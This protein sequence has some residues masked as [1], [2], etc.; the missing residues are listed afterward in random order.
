MIV[1]YALG[2]G[3]GHLTRVRA[4]AHTLGHA[5]D[6]V[7]IATVSRW[8][9]DRRVTGGAHVV[10]LA[11]PG[12]KPHR[13]QLRSSV[14]ALCADP[15]VTDL[16]VDAFP[17]GLVGELSGFDAPAHVRVTYLARL[18]RWDRYGRI[19][20]T[21][22]PPRIDR[23]LRVEPLAHAHDR[24]CGRNG[25]VVDDLIL[26]DPPLRRDPGAA[27]LAAGTWLVVHSGPDAETD[28]LVHAARSAGAA[29]V[30]VI[31]PGGR[32]EYP[33]WPLFPQAAGIITAAGF[34]CVRQAAPWRHKHHAV[35]MA[36]RFDDQ[37]VRA[38]RGGW[39][40]AGIRDAGRPYG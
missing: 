10:T 38:E 5:A 7:V 18:L 2:G 24:W 34:N 21:G 37:H 3:L 33:A 17:C 22:R 16:L 14:A 40:Q 28:V 11:D 13:E 15:G 23:T 9:A 30:Q 39:R 12:T 32:D 1:A 25:G 20:V 26:A 8:A 35:A 4:A 29:R 19:A 36:R 31:G 6:E 27:D